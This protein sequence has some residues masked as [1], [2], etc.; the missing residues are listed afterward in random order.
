MDN[1]RSFLDLHCK[2]KTPI[3]PGEAWERLTRKIDRLKEQ[4]CLKSAAL[5]AKNKNAGS[6]A[7][8][9]NVD[10]VVKSCI[11]TFHL[12]SHKCLPS[13]AL[14][15]TNMIASCDAAIQDLKQFVSENLLN[16]VTFVRDLFNIEVPLP[17]EL[18]WKLHK[19]EVLQIST[20]VF[21]K[22]Q[23]GHENFLA[24][25]VLWLLTHSENSPQY[26][27]IVIDTFAALLVASQSGPLN[28][29]MS[30]ICAGTV[31][32][33]IDDIVRWMLKSSEATKLDFRYMESSSKLQVA[34]G[35]EGME[36]FVLTHLLRLLNEDSTPHSTQT[37]L[38]AV[39]I[40]EKTLLKNV[41]VSFQ[42]FLIL[43]VKFL[44]SEVVNQ[45]ASAL[46]KPLINWEAIFLITDA[47]VKEM[48]DFHENLKGLADELIQ[49]GLEGGRQN[50]LSA[51]F[52]LARHCCTCDSSSFS[53]YCVWFSTHFGPDSITA[54]S[55]VQ[56][57]SLLQLLTE[58]VP[59]ESAEN[60]R[61]HINKVP[62]A[63]TSCNSV[64]HDYTILARTRLA[65]LNESSELASLFS[66]GRNYQGL[67]SRQG[68]I[69]KVLQH[70]QQTREIM[71]PVLEASIFRRQYYRNTFLVELLGLP[72]SSEES[73][74]PEDFELNVDTQHEFIVALKAMGKIPEKLY[75]T[76][77]NKR[78][79]QNIQ[80]DVKGNNPCKEVVETKGEPLDQSKRKKSLKVRKKI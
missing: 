70:F 38:S 37:L 49:V 43:I 58:I 24:T 40:Q 12:A 69:V 11:Q 46:V 8:K 19:A 75:M 67:D 21:R 27:H 1:L 35:A 31:Q 20:Y 52:L 45:L 57:Q 30:T 61:I 4:R 18:V 79:S 64:L 68:D 73:F 56:F 26:V 15:P 42:K 41:S 25:P 76:Y 60:L 16:K 72:G 6:I 17:L 66:D 22:I 5:K 36:R 77:A 59:V 62:Q 55:P 33:C 54:R 9:K 65:D 10:S 29:H 51:G 78:L 13:L 44:G 32:K 14:I 39:K 2:K 28:L 74:K 50:E 80:E 53:S 48:P 34:V 47:T 7:E 23:P 71:K 3:P 63:P